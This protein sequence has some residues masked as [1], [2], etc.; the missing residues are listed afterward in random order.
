MFSYG[1]RLNWDQMSTSTST[2][3]GGLPCFTT[4][5]TYYFYC[6]IPNLTLSF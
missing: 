4:F 5:A 6:M 1:C 2:S 3:A